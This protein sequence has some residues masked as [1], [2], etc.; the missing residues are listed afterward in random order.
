MTLK[1]V[2]PNGHCFKGDGSA[3]QNSWLRISSEAPD[4]LNEI[5]NKLGLDIERTLQSNL[6][7]DG[8]FSYFPITFLS[9]DKG[10][11]QASRVVF[12]LGRDTL[13][14]LEPSPAPRPL[15]TAMSRL[16]RDGLSVG[17]FETFAVILEALNDAID[18][19]L[20]SLND[21][22]GKVLVQTNAVLNSLEARDRD[23]GV[24][25]VVSTQLDLGE[26]EELLSDC[27]EC[28]LQLALAAR[29]AL[30]RLPTRDAN[31]K[32]QFRTLIE[33]IEAVEDH[34]TFVHD[35]VRLLQTTN[36]MALNVKQNQIVKVFSVVTAVFLPAMLISTY[37]SMNVASMPILEWKYGEPMIIALTAGLALLPLIYVKH[38]GWLR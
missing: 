19:L 2:P 31:L 12:V 9:A 21:V 20:D 28:Q 18:E 3:P 10:H 1:H 38:R 23:F 16:Q 15:D 32:P 34:V 25:D 7:Q 26:V 14:S 37:Y 17:N 5:K 24:S 22:L 30:S 33:D 29:H 35:R 6:S 11:N 4:K 36:N 27:I 13:I 8:E